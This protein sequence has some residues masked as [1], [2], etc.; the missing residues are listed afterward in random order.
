MAADRIV[1]N[2]GKQPGNRLVY[3]ANCLLEVR[4]GVRDLAAIAAHGV[5]GGAATVMETDFGLA[6]GAGPNLTT[7]LGLMDTLLNTN[8]TVAGQTRLDQLNEFVFRIAGQ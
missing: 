1:I 3:L 2:K 8:A 7:L 4:N 5:N 6:A